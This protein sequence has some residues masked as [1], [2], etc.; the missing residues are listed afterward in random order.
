M[1]IVCGIDETGRGCGVGS[2]FL[3]AFI[4]TSNDFVFPKRI[5]DSKKINKTQLENIFNEIIDLENSEFVFCEITAGELDKFNKEKV[6]LNQVEI[7]FCKRIIEYILN[8]YEN[9]TIIIDKF[10]YNLEK[11]LSEFND[12]CCL[13]IE[14]KADA[15]Y[16]QVSASSIIL[17][18]I[19]E[20]HIKELN[21]SLYKIDNKYPLETS[22]YLGDKKLVNYLLSQDKINNN[23]IHYYREFYKLK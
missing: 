17:K 2:M 11:H 10:D 21:E 14:N 16:K 5:Q 3:G 6:N 13:I 23:I 12:R 9:P 4:T 1:S 8:K 20:R 18:T 7:I 19:R 22:G 15:K